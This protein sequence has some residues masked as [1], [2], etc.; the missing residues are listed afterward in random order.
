MIYYIPIGTLTIV[1]M[2]NICLGQILN[3][4]IGNRYD[5]FK[6]MIVAHL[7]LYIPMQFVVM[8]YSLVY[9]IWNIKSEDMT[10][11]GHIGFTILL[12]YLMTFIVLLLV[13]SDQGKVIDSSTTF[14]YYYYYIIH[15]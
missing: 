3:N 12:L 6:I 4:F 9:R 11:K 1:Y 13:L 8:R 14:Y 2:Y 15:F 7:I 10:I 5:F